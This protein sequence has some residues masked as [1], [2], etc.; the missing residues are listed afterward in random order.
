MHKIIDTLIDTPEVFLGLEVNQDTLTPKEKDFLDRNGY[1]VLHNILNKDQIVTFRQRLNELTQLEGHSAGAVDQTP[2]QLQVNRNDL[3][4]WGRIAAYCYNLVFYL[5]KAIAINWLFKYN[6]NLKL[7][8]R[9]RSGSPEFGS[10][11]LKKFGRK[12]ARNIFDWITIEV[13]EMLTAAAFTEA[14]ATRICNLINKDD[15]FDVCF[16]HPKVLA[17]VEQVIGTQIKVSSINYRAA[18]PN[19]GLQPLHSDWEE[20]VAPGNYIACNTLW[21]LDDFTEDNG[22]TRIVPGS[23]L[24][25]QIPQEVMKDRLADHPEQKLILAPAG[26]VLIMNSHAWHGGTLNRTD[27][28]RR[29]IQSYFVR[30]NQVP[31]LNQREYVR[32]ATLARL[33]PEEKVLLDVD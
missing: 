26:S 3:S 33:T 29:I 22:A 21:I 2:Y 9:A 7:R 24:R 4:V 30:R 17:A 10:P 8:L 28:L 11:Q 13:R 19:G 27:N 6:P 15:L 18:K 20:A 32:K 25:N 31:Q 12:Q 23:H 5:V 14:G 16:Q 1:L